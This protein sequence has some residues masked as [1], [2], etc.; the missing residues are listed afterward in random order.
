M[1]A[2][3]PEADDWRYC[4]QSIA[5]SRFMVLIT[6]LS[7][8]CSPFGPQLLR[9]PSLG[10]NSFACGLASYDKPNSRP[11]EPRVKD[12]FWNV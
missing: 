3:A 10:D 8:M 4:K 6:E 5:C 11:F 9:S 7:G 12:D 2:T 1:A